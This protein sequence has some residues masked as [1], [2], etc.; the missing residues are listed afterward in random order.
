MTK[1]EVILQTKLTALN[2]IRKVYVP[3]YFQGR[4]R[5][6]ATLWEMREEEIQSIITELEN[7]LKKLKDK[8]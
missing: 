2:Q 6:G 1:Q 8:E 4:D 3:G 5:M 7:N